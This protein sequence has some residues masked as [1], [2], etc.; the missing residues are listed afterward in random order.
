MAVL[1]YITGNT[2]RR[3][4]NFRTDRHGGIGAIDNALSFPQAPDSCFGIRSESSVEPLPTALCPEVLDRVRSVDPEYLRAA[5]TDA[6]L[7]DK[8]VAGALARL[9]E[10]ADN[11]ATHG[12]VCGGD[13]RFEQQLVEVFGFPPGAATASDALHS[14]PQGSPVGRRR[15]RGAVGRQ[16][17][18]QR[19]QGDVRFGCHQISPCWSRPLTGRGPRF[20]R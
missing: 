16:Y 19:G 20:L 11:G 14:G 13:E 4:F 2:D 5:W 17:T 3:V 10:I 15:V 18:D 6:G 7:T 12:T 1:D 8:A 9:Q